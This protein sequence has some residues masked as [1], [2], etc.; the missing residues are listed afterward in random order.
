M[1]FEPQLADPEPLPTARAPRPAR[2]SGYV[3][4]T[5]KAPVTGRA[6]PNRTVGSGRTA[7]SRPDPADRIV[8]GTNQPE[9]HGWHRSDASV[10]LRPALRKWKADNPGKGFID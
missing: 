8:P 4:S 2:D 5:P 1:P 3:S 6:N 9:R 10:N 7:S